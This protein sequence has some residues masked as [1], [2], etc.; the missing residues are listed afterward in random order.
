[1]KSR[2]GVRGRGGFETRPYRLLHTT[3]L[4]VLLMIG[5]E[6]SVA[7]GGASPAG[8]VL[9]DTMTPL[10]DTA[11]LTNRSTWK[12]VPPNLLLL[13]ADPLKASSD[14]GYYGREYEFRGDAVVENSYLTA[15][16]WSGKGKV[17]VSSKNSKF[18]IGGL[19][20]KMPRR[21]TVLQNTGDDVAL[22]VSFPSADKPRNETAVLAFGKTPIIEIKPAEATQ[23]ISLLSPI[24]YGIVPGFIGDD[25]IL[26]PSQYPSNNTLYA[27]SENVFLGLLKGESGV[28]VVTWPKAERQMTSLA[29]SEPDQSS[30]LFELIGLH[31][32]G[33]SVYVALL[34]A[35]GIWHRE[36][37]GV[38]YLEKDVASKWKKPF[39]AKWV[40]QLWEGDV[41]TTY[42]FREA[43]AGTIWRGVAG[44]YN[45][46]L[47]FDGDAAWYHLSKKVLPKGESIIYFLEGQ[48]T[49]A[50]VLTPVDVM[51]ATL[52]RQTCDGIL[53]LAGRKLRTH[54]RRGAAG[55]RRAC[56]CGCTEAIEAVFHAGQEIEKKD[57]IEGAVGD[58]VY[59]VTRHMERLNEYRT[60]ADETSK[61]LRA[62]ASSQPELKTYL[63]G[64]TQIVQR[65]PDEYSVQKENIKSLE[66]AEEL[67]RKT[68]ALL[69]K[70]DP[71]NLPA[72]L[73]LGKDWR[74]MGGAQDGLLAEYHIL[75]RKL[76]QEAGYGCVTQPKAVEVAREIRNRCRQCLR[77]PDGY[78]IWPN[79]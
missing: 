12:A 26:S 67:S 17:V 64:L 65:I 52:G 68:L 39:P 16:V 23:E 69:Q 13:E 9:W 54:H 44:M 34:E 28:L 20:G 30:R 45:Y 7:R 22:E 50:S 58:M 78:E 24:E 4:V 18:E 10:G 2:R 40:T 46:P 49:P 61:F 21:C 48:N 32:R 70:K 1:M 31:S 42:T 37:L 76:F 27:P 5:T 29:F 79:Y 19:E 71:K 56:T 55:I 43:P 60:F 59:F 75:V 73:E 41:R 11:D 62:T 25:L 36:P 15:V 63:D 6:M 53:D 38:S 14:P 74:G 51:K 33:Q 66:Y 57:Y 35:P 3:A 72:C 47:W 8:V 77:N